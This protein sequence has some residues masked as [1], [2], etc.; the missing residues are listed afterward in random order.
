M[1]D[2]EPTGSVEAGEARVAEP[3]DDMSA[4]N[5]PMAELSSADI[6]ARDEEFG[7][8]EP[9][10]PGPPIDFGPVE[11]VAGAAEERPPEQMTPPSPPSSD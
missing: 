7:E 9:L 3:A 6:S 10:P 8:L 1:S 11:E 2:V 5:P 4:D